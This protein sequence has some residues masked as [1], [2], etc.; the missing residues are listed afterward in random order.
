MR[1]TSASKSTMNL[2]VGYGLDFMERYR[3]LPYVGV[4]RKELLEQPNIMKR[5]SAI[6]CAVA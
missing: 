3:N 2:S 4:L 6:L 5:A 1:I